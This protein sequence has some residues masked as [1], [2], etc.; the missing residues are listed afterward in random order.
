MKKLFLAML[1]GAVALVGCRTTAERG[2]PAGN[3]NA[4]RGHF[5]RFGRNRHDYGRRITASDAIRSGC[6]P[7]RPPR[8]RTSALIIKVTATELTFEVPEGLPAGENSV[9]LKQA[10]PK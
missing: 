3:N 7:K 9:I 1:I 5:V 10:P 2:R 8:R 4:R 6:R